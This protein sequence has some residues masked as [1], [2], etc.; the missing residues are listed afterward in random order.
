[1]D[2]IIIIII[3]IIKLIIR[4]T[5]PTLQS[6]INRKKSCLLVE[7]NTSVKVAEKLSKNIKTLKS[8][9]KEFGVGKPQQFR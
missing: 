2:I 8:K 3:T 9:L 5:D 6:R 1:M 7:K 4:P